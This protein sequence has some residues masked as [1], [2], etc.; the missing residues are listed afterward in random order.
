MAHALIV[1]EFF[2]AV[3][4]RTLAGHRRIEFRG[5]MLTLHYRRVLC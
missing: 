4:E 1:F 5:E 3:G 2:G